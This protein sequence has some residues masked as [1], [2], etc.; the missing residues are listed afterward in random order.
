M[1]LQGQD[2]WRAHPVFRNLWRHAFPGFR[3]G[4]MAFGVF[5]VAETAY[6]LVAPKQNHAHSAY[7]H[8][9][10]QWV[11]PTPGGLPSFGGDDDDADE[12][13]E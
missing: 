7:A 13:D 5:V 10:S 9:A 4:A 11:R 3:L 12:D 2:A 8:G 1:V 6:G